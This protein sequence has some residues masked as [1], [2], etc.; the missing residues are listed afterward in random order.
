MFAATARSE[1]VIASVASPNGNLTVDVSLTKDGN[2][3]YS[4][5]RGGQEI[6]APS[7]LG[8]ILANAP[9]LDRNFSLDST[10][11]SAKDETWEQPWGERRFV[12]NHYNELSVTVVQKAIDSR[13]MTLVFRVFDDGL[14]FRYSFPDQPQLKTLKITDELTE[15][16][17]VDPATAW[18]DVA[19]EW[20]READLYNRTPLKEVSEAQTPITLK[21]DN[22]LYLSIHEAAL[23]DYAA[24]WIRRV[25][26]QRLKT[27]LAP[28]SIGANVERDAPFSTPW[29][30][31]IVTDNA[32]ALYESNIELNLNEPNKLGDVSWIKPCKYVG[33]WWAMHLN[34]KT[35]EAGPK[36]GATTE[37][38]ERYMD[39]AAANGF[40]GVLVEGWNSAGRIGLRRAT[41]ILLPRATLTSISSGR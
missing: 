24:Y 37:E 35:W 12:R 18:W 22:G 1:A 38:A 13:R 29:R 9:K 3:A 34:Q 36:H 39:F 40:R 33:I 16:A 41:N 7:R 11:T 15:F 19:G 26:G 25:E 17:V 31:L 30:T 2:V 32:P 14:G 6:I 10:S 20:N 28:S 5:K 21:T 8:L 4:V 27:R 23:V